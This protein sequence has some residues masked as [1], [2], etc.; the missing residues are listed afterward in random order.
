[1]N[2]DPEQEMSKSESMENLLRIIHDLGEPHRTVLQMHDVDA[3][4][5][6]EVGKVLGLSAGNVRVV[7]SRARKKVRESL[8]K[9]YVNGKEENRSLIAE[10]L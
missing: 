10:I 1:D 8:E 7:L 9:M 3:Y 2:T 6:E 5:K 4:S